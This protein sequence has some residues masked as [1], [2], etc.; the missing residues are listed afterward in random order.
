MRS[1]S[2]ENRSSEPP[3]T[4][5]ELLERLARH[6][7]NLNRIASRACSSRSE[8]RRCA[9]ELDLLGSPFP[10]SGHRGEVDRDQ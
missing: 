8:I 4:W 10:R 5:R 1:K 6:I 9:R 7:Q 3:V 2:R